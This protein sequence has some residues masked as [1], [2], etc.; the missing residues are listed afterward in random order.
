[1]NNVIDYFPSL[2]NVINGWWIL[3]FLFNCF[4][5]LVHIMILYVYLNH[6]TRC[7]L[8]QQ[9]LGS[10]SHRKFGGLL[11]G[12]GTT[13]RPILVV[14]T[15]LQICLL[16]VVFD[17]SGYTPAVN[18]KLSQKK[19]TVFL[20]TPKSCLSCTYQTVTFQNM[21]LTHLHSSPHMTPY[22]YRLIALIGH[23]SHLDF[24]TRYCMLWILLFV[25]NARNI[26]RSYL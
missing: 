1:M 6:S 11:P 24:C 17:P 16:T 19:K 12:R 4:S 9:G 14:N 25:M 8:Q 21:R 20:A 10:Q 3:I 13:Y 7:D 18:A 2:L 26:L 22:K 15:R 5:E 23:R